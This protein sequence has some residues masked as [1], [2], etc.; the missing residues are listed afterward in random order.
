M[1]KAQPM[2]FEGGTYHPC[3]ANLATHI[4]LN[5]PGPIPTRIIPLDRWTWNGDTEKPTLNPSILSQCPP[6]CE[7]CH[8]L[9]TDGKVRFLNDC[10]HELAGQTLDLLD[11]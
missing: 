5:M 9:V 2:R 4:I 11:V 7:C 1:M 8:T 6:I 3:E 10:S